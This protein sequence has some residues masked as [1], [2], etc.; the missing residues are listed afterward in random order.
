MSAQKKIPIVLFACWLVG[1]LFW[2]VTSS[3]SAPTALGTSASK[4]TSS[5]IAKHK[6]I[7]KTDCKECHRALVQRKNLHP[8]GEDCANCHEYSET[9]EGA[10]V[11]L[12]SEGTALCFTCHSDK[13]E[14]FAKKKFKHSAAEAD[15]TLC[16]NPH[17][18]D[19]P[20]L[21][22]DKANQLCYICH[23]D[24]EEEL[25]KKAF[26]HAPT[27]DVGCVTCHNPHTADFSSLLKV[28]VNDLCLACHGMSAGNKKNKAS[29]VI[30]SQRLMPARYADKAKKVVLGRDGKGHPYIG[31]PVSD[32]PD[33]SKPTEIMSCL[34]CHNPHA[35]K[36]VQMFK[37][38]MAKSELC[39]RCH[40]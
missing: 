34:S 5:S 25:T 24:R 28:Q 37:G 3:S 31:H 15:C 30:F 39:D 13:Q 40:K 29:E 7:G 14:D 32:V 18:S 12:A 22:K 33:P 17:S 6:K 9:K 21:L 38:D 36:V 35:G 4:T 27:K 11:K 1:V 10:E 19:E 23:S 26:V 2:T 16:H 20:A 8:V